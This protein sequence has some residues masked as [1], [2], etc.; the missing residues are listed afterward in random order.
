MIEAER[1]SLA[2]ELDAERKAHA[3]EL[4]A[5]DA[6]YA[7]LSASASR[8]NLTEGSSESSRVKSQATGFQAANAH[9]EEIKKQLQSAQQECVRLRSELEIQKSKTVSDKGQGEIKAVLESRAE[10]ESLKLK[11]TK[12]NTKNK[13][14]VREVRNLEVEFVDYTETLALQPLDRFHN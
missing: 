1:T 8:G 14:L 4:Q 2:A 6:H 5:K 11:P 9:T 3:I 12:A 13:A 10:V 7:R